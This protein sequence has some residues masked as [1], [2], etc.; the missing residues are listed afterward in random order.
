MVMQLKKG[1][2]A[3]GS[4]VVVACCL[5]RSWLPYSTFVVTTIGASF[6]HAI[7]GCSEFNYTV[8][9]AVCWM[10]LLGDTVTEEKQENG[11]VT[12]DRAYKLYQDELVMDREERLAKTGF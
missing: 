2:L 1:F 11:V 12:M 5:D 7:E 10:L 8:V 3:A 9:Q 4:G 6:M